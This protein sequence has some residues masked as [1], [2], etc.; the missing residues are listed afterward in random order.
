MRI[1]LFILLI[2]SCVLLCYNPLYQS[3]WLDEAATVNICTHKNQ[4]FID[5][6]KNDKHPPLY[7]FICKRFLINFNISPLKGLRLLSGIFSIILLALLYTLYCK[8]RISIR[9][10]I[11][12]CL[13][14]FSPVMFWVSGEARMY[15]MNIL[16][17]TILYILLQFEFIRNKTSTFSFSLVIT[18]I[19]IGIYT[20]YYFFLYALIIIINY[21]VMKKY[22]RAALVF[23]ISFI[24]YLPWG[25]HLY[26]DI[27]DGIQWNP[28][29]SIKLVP[30]TFFKFT[31][32][33]QGKSFFM[34][35]PFLAKTLIVY[36]F[37]FCFFTGLIAIVEKGKK[38][39]FFHIG[40]LV[41]IFGISSLLSISFIKN[42]FLPK[43]FYMFLPFYLHILAEGILYM[44]KWVSISI[45]VMIFTIFSLFNYQ[46]FTDDTLRGDWNRIQE[47]LSNKKN[48][49]KIYFYPAY[50]DLPLR[51]MHNGNLNSFESLNNIGINKKSFDDKRIYIIDNK[52][53]LSKFK[54]RRIIL[55]KSAKIL[56]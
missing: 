1:T 49:S 53:D 48:I 17:G 28:V 51:I 15:S 29:Y 26:N 4:S 41:I 19:I 10:T 34:S 13:F 47:Y 23:I 11:F 46:Y 24:V 21:I 33:G 30:A 22:L 8:N 18:F 14:C 35:S 36:V 12:F 55:F 9:E 50:M 39:T 6:V 45:A 43:Y 52:I 37:G 20:H 56:L 32:G 5:L 38:N 40:N 25:M 2:I 3:I 44:K 42:V 7:Y 27:I 16:I 31:L 54:E